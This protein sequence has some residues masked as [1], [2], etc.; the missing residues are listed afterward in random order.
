VPAGS[1]AVAVID[2]LTVEPVPAEAR[3]PGECHL[4]APKWYYALSMGRNS[5]LSSIDSAGRVVIPKALRERLQLVPGSEIEISA[6]KGGLRIERVE[7]E[8]RLLRV[9][10][11]LVF[12]GGDPHSVDLDAAIAA[13]RGTRDREIVQELQPKKRTRK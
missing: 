4:L 7:R 6:H 2:S 13:A 5:A 1:R 11:R 3:L 10:G 8:G 12:T 9:D